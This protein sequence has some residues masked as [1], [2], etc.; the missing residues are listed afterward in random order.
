MVIDDYAKELIRIKALQLIGKGGFTESDREDIEQELTLDL[1]ERLPQYNPER[2]S[3]HTF[4]ARVVDHKIAR[5]I[6]RRT[7]A[8]RDR[9]RT[10]VSLSR[11]VDA[12]EGRQEPLAA[13]VEEGGRG[14]HVSEARL[15]DLAL[16]L[17]EVLGGLPKQLR[18]LCEL[19][20]E[21]D[22]R[23]AAEEM[24]VTRR[25][26]YRWIER[27]RGHFEDAGLDEYL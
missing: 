16:D 19:L 3:E 27:A 13:T 4:M 6:E 25:T 17:T 7:A 22:I 1:L 20:S 5:L 11:P 2:A 15:R 10:V 24:G 18:T 9:T 8:K 21:G 14:T 23:E 12:D 26:I